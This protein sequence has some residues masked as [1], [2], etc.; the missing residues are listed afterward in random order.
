[1]LAV[2]L[3][4]LPDILLLR[5]SVLHVVEYMPVR[6]ITLTALDVLPGVTNQIELGLLRLEVFQVQ[7]LGVDSSEEHIIPFC[8]R[9]KGNVEDGLGTA[10]VRLLLNLA[11]PENQIFFPYLDITID[12]QFINL[13]KRIRLIQLN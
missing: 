4:E 8:L 10:V 9:F 7:A 2:Q 13:Y 5:S 6:L 1:M 3:P 11:T 12:W